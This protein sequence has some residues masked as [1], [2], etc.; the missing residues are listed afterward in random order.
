VLAMSLG[1][2]LGAKGIVPGVE[3]LVLASG[4]LKG[5]RRCPN[6]RRGRGQVLLRVVAPGEEEEGVCLLFTQNGVDRFLLGWAGAGLACGLSF[7]LLRGLL[8]G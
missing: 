1:A 7:G 3:I 5:V 2:N 8:L 6:P 4:I